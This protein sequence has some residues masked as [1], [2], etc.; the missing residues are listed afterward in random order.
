MHDRRIKSALPE[1][2]ISAESDEKS[3]SI[4][5]KGMMC[6]HCEARVK[7]ALEEVSGIEEARPDHESG[8]VKL[9]MN[10][11]VSESE[12]KDAIEKAGYKF[13]GYVK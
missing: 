2:D 12:I 9:V 11:E 7:T 8:I 4:R 13:K 6:G 1:S 3:T 10:A 5:V